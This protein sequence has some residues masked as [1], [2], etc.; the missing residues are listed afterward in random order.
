MNLLRLISILCVCSFAL[1]IGS[2]ETQASIINFSGQLDYIEYDTGT[3]VYSGVAIG[4]TF[5]G[6]IDDVNANGSISD[7]VTLTSFSCCIAAGGL[8]I[9]NDMVLSEDD[10]TLLNAIVGFSK[11]SAGDLVDGVNIEGDTTT[12]S[13]GRIEIGLSYIFPPTTFANDNLSNYPF[14]P[15]DIQLALFFILE[16]DNL[17]GDIYHGVGQISSPKVLFWSMEVGQVYEYTRRDST[18]NSW[19]TTLEVLGTKIFNDKSYFHLRQSN[20]RPGEVDE[21][22]WRS[23]E[24]AIYSWHDTGE[25]LDWQIGPTGTV[26]THGDTVTEIMG[27]ESVTVPYGGP[28]N[29]YKYRNYNSPESSPYWYNYLVPGFGFIKEVDYWTDNPPKIQELIN[30]RM[31]TKKAMPWIP[32]L[33]LDE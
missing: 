29:A 17:G 19:S 33:L 25:T 28:Y 20:Y 10:A 8:S 16:E 27:V 30:I 6:N 14:N 7:G 2:L 1:I 4:T 3:G 9:S 31:D 12:S 15:N 18:G 13:G 26:W 21:F 22:Y 5:S 23:T 11:Y 32:L 24:N